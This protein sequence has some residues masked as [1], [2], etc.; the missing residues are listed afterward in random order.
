MKNGQRGSDKLRANCSGVETLTRE[1]LEQ[2]A[3]GASFDGIW[4]VF[5][6]GIPWPELFHNSPLK[7]VNEAVAL[8][9]GVVNGIGENLKNPGYLYKG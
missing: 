8:D 9:Q 6:R 5:P 2:V 1:E 7:T 3:G 4:R